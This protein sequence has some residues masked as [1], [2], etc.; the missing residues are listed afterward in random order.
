MMMNRPHI[1]APSASLLLV[2]LALAQPN[3]AA[4]QANAALEQCAAIDSESQRLACYDYLVRANSQSNEAEPDTSVE[5]QRSNIPRATVAVDAP[6]TETANNYSRAEPR[7]DAAEVTGRT[8]APATEPEQ[9]RG[10]LFSRRGN[11]DSASTQE[12]VVIVDVRTSISDLRIFTTEDGRVFAQTST[13]TV[14]HDD[15]PFDARIEPASFGSF[16]LIPEGGR[17]RVR[18]S[19]RE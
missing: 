15:P 17:Q 3:I 12:S 19:L 2:V 10:G 18:V 16:F 8:A 7:T 13:N 9:S 6:E 4:A 14:S 1:L 11:R 5:A